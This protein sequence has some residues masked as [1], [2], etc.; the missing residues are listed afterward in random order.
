MI[1]GKTVL[2][3]MLWRF[4]ERSG[5]QLV[6]FL[7][8]LVLARLLLPEDY[9]IISL[10][11]VF[12]TILNLFVDGGFGNALIQKQDADQTDYSTVFYFNVFLGIVLY[13]G[14]YF[15]APGIAAFY[16]RGDMVPYIRGLSLTLIIG[17]V[18]GVQHA[19]VAKRMEYKR[20]FYSSLGGTLLSAV[21]GVGMAFLGFGAWAL[22]AQRVVDQ[23]VDTVILWFTVRWRPSGCFSPK[24]LRPLASYGSRLL[25]SSLL[26]A[27]S[28][29]LTGLLVG[30]MYSAAELAF[31][32]KGER[33][34]MLLISNLQAAAQS[35]LFPA[36]AEL[37]TERERVRYLL[38]Q[39]VMA[40]AYCIFPCMIGLAACAE[41]VVRILY[42]EKWIGMVPYLRFWC[43]ILIF[44][45]LHTANLQ[46]IQALGRSDIFLRIE[47]IKQILS[48]AGI[49]I[50][51]PFGVLT[52]MAVMCVENLAF[53]YINAAPN[54]M[55]AG[56][57]FWQQLKD[58]S[59]IIVLN[60][61]LG[62]L[63]CG[64]G[65]LPLPDILLLAVQIAAGAAFY[66]G[67]SAVLKIEIFRRILDLLK[68][69]VK[70]K[71]RD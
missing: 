45:L 51:I 27:L 32:D 33:V 31:Y 5:T 3:N 30:K 43:F 13:A 34:P 48:I 15:A 71:G 54:H 9:G 1:K 26:N 67:G 37:Q 56:Y 64:I 22:I 46:V 68:W 39:S 4:A 20:F 11:T 60:L 12:T 35:V 49:M 28:T 10:I 16:E 6:S 44:Y 69:I 19:L 42:T 18:N 58:I 50:A 61:L 14:M 40:A 36:I 41:S 2:S 29:N 62:L 52:M 55:L 17:G 21:I 23:A 66:I 63:V 53:Y 70:R 65:L 25:G 24:R 57:G 7:V 59:P 8:S 47:I 38:R